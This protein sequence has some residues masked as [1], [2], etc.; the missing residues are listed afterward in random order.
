M[1]NTQDKKVEYI[2]LIYDLIFVYLIGR[3]NSLLDRIENGFISF[4]T[5]GNYLLSSLIIL[6]VWYY[7]M[8][9]INRFG[10]NGFAEKFMMFFN[11]F[12]LYIMGS[13]TING[14]DQNYP[15]YMTA[16]ILIL[17]CIALQYGLKLRRQDL[18]CAKGLIVRTM[19]IMVLQALLIGIS[20]PVYLRTGLPLGQ[21]T[22]FIG[23]IAV[24]AL[25]IKSNASVNF[26]HLSERVML[27]VVFT[28]GEMIITV[29]GYFSDGLTLQ[30]LFF[31]FISF[32]TTAGLFF[33]YGFV[34]DKLLDRKRP[35]TGSL[36]TLLHVFLILSLSCTTIAL[37][38]MRNSEVSA[39]PK[40]LFL[41]ISLMIFFICLAFTEH[42]SVKRIGP[43]RRFSLI[44]LAEFAVYAAAMMLSTGSGYALGI[45]TVLFIYI[46][47]G[48][49]ILS[50]RYTTDR[51]S[52]SGHPD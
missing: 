44:M 46:Q 52:A 6:Q 32:L 36:Y 22:V 30:T 7:T 15:A 31:A 40:T 37:D 11:M 24:P 48:T 34:Y 1:E 8:F 2:E 19:A 28:F 41:V 51:S 38:F 49:L 9:F 27:Y 47:L 33:S 17:L 21:W 3:S 45:I 16:W 23:I 18:D 35:D 4:S 29:A 12:L 42:W 20:I 39:L 50:G 43:R 25:N 5:F 10:R 14:W 13:N 26:E